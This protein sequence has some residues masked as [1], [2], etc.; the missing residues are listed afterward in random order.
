MEKDPAAI[1]FI[2]QRVIN[3]NQGSVRVLPL[4]R[5]AG[6]PFVTPSAQTFFDASYPLHNGAYIYLNRVPGQPLGAREK[7]FVRFL[8]SREGQQIIA[9]NRLFIPLNAAQAQA[10]LAKLD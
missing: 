10:E 4:A 2:F 7:E 8:L 5:T 6:Q 3:A 9:D 1:G